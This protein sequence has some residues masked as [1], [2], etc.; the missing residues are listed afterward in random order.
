METIMPKKIT[1]YKNLSIRWRK[2]RNCFVLDLGPIGGGKPL[3]DTKA[4][5]SQ[6]A[7][8]MFEVFETGKPAIE[9]KPWTVEKANQKYLEHCQRRSE[10][11]DS[12]Y[13]PSSLTNQRCHLNNCAKLSFDGLALAKKN[14]ADLDVDF[15]EQD[16]WPALKADCNTSITA[17]NRFGAFRQMMFWCVKRKQIPS[18]PCSKAD[19]ETPDRKLLW[20]KKLKRDMARVDPDNLQTILSHVEPQHKLKVLFALE[21]GL[22]IGEQVAVKI[23]DPK[24]PEV[25]GIEFKTNIVHVE[26]ALKKGA[27]HSE[28]FIDMPKS[29]SGIRQVPITPELSQ[30]LKEYWMALPVKMKTEGWLFPSTHGTMGC[31][32]NW[33]Q[34]ILYPA[35]EQA[36]LPR[37]RWPTWHGLRHAFCTTYLNQRGGNADRAKEL[38]GHS[39]YQTTLIYKHFVADP[40]RDQD[41]AYAVSKGLGLDINAT[42]PEA[43]EDSTVVPLKLKKAS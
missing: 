7:Q 20:K 18:N 42:P 26:Q 1:S 33:R 17:L 11:P 3:F 24:K 14:V 43:P 10:D 15:I 12:D 27:K 40:E 21:T 30:M 38:M 35:C 41:D 23:Y 4:E 39:S 32:T 28:A 8:E 29:E 6:H 5:A 25:G 34:R 22:R 37:E 19:I 16:F 2:D 13:G 9:I 31:G 36:G